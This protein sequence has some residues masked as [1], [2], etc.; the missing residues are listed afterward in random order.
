[1][2]LKCTGRARGAWIAPA[3]ILVLTGGQACGILDDGACPLW[4]PAGIEID[5]VEAGTGRVVPRSANP[6]GFTI[7]GRLRVREPMVLIDVYPY[8][9]VLE[10][11]H[12]QPGVYDVEIAADG[13]ETWRA[14]DISVE[15][16]NCGHART[17]EMTARLLP[18]TRRHMDRGTDQDSPAVAGTRKP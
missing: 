10:G 16:D 6:T 13:Y 4:D 7:K 8:R 5:V 11:A 1:M 14:S 18:S 17:V 15:V 2:L 9:T 12:S 3:T